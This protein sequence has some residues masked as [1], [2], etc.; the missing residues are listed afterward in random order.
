MRVFKYILNGRV[1]NAIF[2]SNL[3]NFLSPGTI[4]QR[5]SKTMT[6]ISMGL[7]NVKYRGMLRRIFF[8][9]M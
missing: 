8:L 9:H 2:V 6:Q 3:F 1:T 4:L 5:V 7:Q